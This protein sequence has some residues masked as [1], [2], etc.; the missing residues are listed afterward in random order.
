MNI[1]PR[2]FRPSAWDKQGLIG[3]SLIASALGG[4]ALP[5][6]SLDLVQSYRL[7]LM[8]DAAFQALR[9]ETAGGHE[10]VP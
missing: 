5:A 10:N 1:Y 2:V 9:S 4:F 7:A 6:H 8:Q 3:A